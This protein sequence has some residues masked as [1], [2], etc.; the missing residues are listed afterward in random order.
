MRKAFVLTVEAIIAF[1]FVLLVLL[2]I[3]N[4]AFQPAIPRSAYIKQLSYDML[5]VLTYDGRLSS[6]LDG[7]TNGVVDALGNLPA[8]ICMQ[9]T[10]RSQSISPSQNATNLTV[11]KVGCG[12]I[13]SQKHVAYG[14]FIKDGVVYSSE[15][16]SWFDD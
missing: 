11:A 1:G 9:V 6:L 4:Q 13:G 12:S 3:A 2:I 10:L 8:H 14:S 16:E 15:I 7:D 5:K